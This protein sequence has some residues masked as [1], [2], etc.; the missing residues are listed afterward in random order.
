MAWSNL[1][2]NPIGRFQAGSILKPCPTPEAPRLMCTLLAKASSLSAT[3]QRFRYSTNVDGNGFIVDL[4]LD[5]H[6]VLLRNNI[7]FRN[8]GAGL[9]TTIS[10]NCQIIN[11]AFVENGFGSTSP[12]RGAGIKLSRDQ[13]IGQTIVNNM[14]VNN[15]DSGILT[16]KLMDKQKTVDHN[17]YFSTA[18]LQKHLI[19]DGYNAGEREYDSLA[20][21]REQ[22]RLEAGGKVG[23]PKFLNV[24]DLN[25][26][27]L[28]E[29]AAIDAG[30]QMESVVDDLSGRD[31]NGPIDIGPLEYTNAIPRSRRV[32]TNRQDFKKKT[33]TPKSEE[34]VEATTSE[35]K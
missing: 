25:F 11:N 9:N 7:A 4:M 8:E 31:R 17:L 20:A 21:V 10:P 30:M 27:L 18:N 14:F 28:P 13:D 16:Y 29:S 6:G 22:L 2:F 33:E 23:D 1:Q 5:G 34:T 32:R 19:W 26:L 3:S 15:A 12:R 24:E 35:K